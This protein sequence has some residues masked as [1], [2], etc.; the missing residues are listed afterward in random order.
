MVYTFL[1]RGRW[2]DDY[3]QKGLAKFGYTLKKEFDDKL[4]G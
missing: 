3:L 4:E 2:V 1:F